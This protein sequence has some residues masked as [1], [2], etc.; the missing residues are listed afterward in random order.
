MGIL[1]CSSS[2]STWRGFEYFE[3][4]KVISWKQLDESQYE[5]IVSGTSSNFFHV[6]IDINQPRKNSFCN[7]P[8]ANGKRIVCKH[9]IALFFTVFPQ[10]AENYMQ[11]I[12][13]EEKEEIQREMVEYQNIEEYV[14][15]LSKEELRTA[16]INALVEDYNQLYY[17]G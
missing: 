3:E 10:E 5:G 11:Q 15:S 4:K 8:L 6:K 1:S 13:E 7:C 14:N 16:L 17:R 12:E 2:A 9:Q